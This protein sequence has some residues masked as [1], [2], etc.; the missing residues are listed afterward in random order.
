MDEKDLDKRLNGLEQRVEQLESELA[1]EE[2]KRIRLG[3]YLTVI[4]VSLVAVVSWM[5][6]TGVHTP[7]V[8]EQVENEVVVVKASE[9][10][11]NH[12]GSV[13]IPAVPNSHGVLKL[14]GEWGVTK[15]PENDLVVGIYGLPKEEYNDT[16]IEVK[17]IRFLSYRCEGLKQEIK[18]SNPVSG[19][20]FEIGNKGV[21]EFTFG[22]E[23]IDATVEG[24]YNKIVKG[25]GEH[26]KFK[27]VNVD[28][29]LF[30]VE[31]V[32]EDKSVPLPCGK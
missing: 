24:N 6:Y 12:T 5:I 20:W 2:T 8:N 31:V 7:T 32:R 27:V 10:V 3:L 30:D 13:V 25:F 17:N 19:A 29:T 18:V 26:D 4:V 21:K 28:G 11:V 23:K 15:T 14:F 1:M 22:D 9:P 16:I